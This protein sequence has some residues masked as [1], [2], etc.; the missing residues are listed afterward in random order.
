MKNI[1]T[2]IDP[3]VLQNIAF[4]AVVL[5]ALLMSYVIHITNKTVNTVMANQ[6]IS[7]E[8]ALTGTSSASVASTTPESN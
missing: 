3:R 7:M 4:T 5:F 6:Q 8:T 2:T 1:S